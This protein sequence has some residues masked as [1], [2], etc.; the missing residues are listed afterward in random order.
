MWQL[1]VRGETMREWQEFGAFNSIGDSAASAPF[2]RVY[3]DPLMGGSDAE[4]LPRL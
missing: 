3:A 2:F 1:S 4:I